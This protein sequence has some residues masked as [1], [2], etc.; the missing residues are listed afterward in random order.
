MR[1]VLYTVAN[2]PLG[3]IFYQLSSPSARCVRIKLLS[4]PA[5]LIHTEAKECIQTEQKRFKRYKRIWT[6]FEAF[7]NYRKKC[8]HICIKQSLKLEWQQKQGAFV[9]RKC[10]Y[11]QKLKW[12]KVIEIRNFTCMMNFLESFTYKLFLTGSASSSVIGVCSS[13]ASATEARSFDVNQ[14][15]ASCR[16]TYSSCCL[17]P[18]VLKS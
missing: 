14:C 13:H 2:V 7:F 8:I 6:H 1:C 9:P 18:Q 16:E 5:T 4:T 15:K 10:M 12:V 3:L 11:G 17:A